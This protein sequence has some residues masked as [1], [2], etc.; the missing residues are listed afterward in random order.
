MHM[1]NIVKSCDI[2]EVVDHFLCETLFIIRD[3]QCLNS[4]RLLFF[5]TKVSWSISFLQCGMFATIL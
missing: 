3:V 5:M 1:V 4:E 2:I